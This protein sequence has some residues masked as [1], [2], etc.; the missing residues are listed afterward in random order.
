MS[1]RRQN[2]IEKMVQFLSKTLW[3]CTIDFHTIKAYFLVIHLK[4]LC[5]NPIFNKKKNYI[6]QENLKPN[7]GNAVKTNSYM[8]MLPT[9]LIE[10]IA[11]LFK[12][13]LILLIGLIAI[14]H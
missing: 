6:M 4:I 5:D 13:K 7:N 11:P 2:T 3:R 1:K 8:N 10:A 9:E 14:R 12:I